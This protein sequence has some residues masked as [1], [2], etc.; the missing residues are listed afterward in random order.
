MNRSSF[1]CKFYVQAIPNLRYTANFGG[2]KV[3]Y[4]LYETF[5]KCKNGYAFFDSL[6]GSDVMAAKQLRQGAVFRRHGIS[7]IVRN[8]HVDRL[9]KQSISKA[10]QAFKETNED[11]V[12]LLPQ[13]S[14]IRWISNKDLWKLITVAP[15]FLARIEDLIAELE[16]AEKMV[17][18]EVNSM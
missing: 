10:I 8:F 15:L 5:Y 14:N 12:D 4:T 9:F 2:Q 17:G 3:H 16:K 7:R 13:I 18:S 1:L 6:N 11:L